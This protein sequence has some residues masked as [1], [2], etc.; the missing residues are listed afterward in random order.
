MENLV[1]TT[2]PVAGRQATKCFSYLNMNKHEIVERTSPQAKLE[3]YFRTN[4]E[5]VGA[6]A[7]A[8]KQCLPMGENSGKLIL[9]FWR[10]T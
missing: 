1:L 7:L 6:E 5:K 8:E 9:D 10:K 2:I 3:Y 4:R